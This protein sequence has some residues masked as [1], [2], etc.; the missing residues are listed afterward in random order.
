MQFQ[1]AY[2]MYLI[3]ANDMHLYTIKKEG[4]KNKQTKVKQIIKWQ[5]MYSVAKCYTF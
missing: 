1:A 2:N 3:Q 4:K 5:S